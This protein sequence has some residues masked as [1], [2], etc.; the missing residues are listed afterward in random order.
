MHDSID[1]A[2]SILM[3]I[4]LIL[5]VI[6]ASIF[7]AAEIYSETITIVQLGNDVLNYTMY[8]QPELMNIFPHGDYCLIY[9][10]CIVKMGK[11]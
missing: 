9:G 10:V 5:T 11:F 8:H 1:T 2:S 4:L 7:C 6:F 3:I